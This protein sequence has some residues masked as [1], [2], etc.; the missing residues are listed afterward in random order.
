MPHDILA[1][2]GPSGSGKTTLILEALRQRPDK[3]GN[4]LSVTTRQ[5]RGT[6][7]DAL[8]Y[9]FVSREEFERRV[10]AGEFIH[11]VEHAGNYYGTLRRHADDVLVEKYAIAA[12]VEQGVRNLRA[13]G[14]SVRVIKIA[15]VGHFAPHDAERIAAD[16][17][18][19]KI[20]VSPDIV[21][22]NDFSPGGRERT[23]AALLMYIDALP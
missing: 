23:I 4:L 9:E 8:T 20:D 14:Y 1:F 11:W 6:A 10:A 2:V 13:S 18:R 3:V 15:P 22:E 19:A 17:A 7:V 21:L 16:A 5:S 12:F